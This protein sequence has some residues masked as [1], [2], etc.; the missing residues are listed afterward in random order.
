M[1]V[2]YEWKILSLEVRDE[3]PDHPNSVVIVKWKKTGRDDDGNEASFQG[4]TPFSAASIPAENFIPYN[5]LTEEIV[6][7][8][9]RE[10]LENVIT[11]GDYSFCENDRVNERIEKQITALK[12][13]VKSESLPW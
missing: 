7:G 1:P 12:A 11:T 2:T 13:P 6:I 3:S 4:S 5:Q 8:W 10:K 9:V